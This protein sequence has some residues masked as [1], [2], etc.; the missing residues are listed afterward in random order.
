MAYQ[1]LIYGLCGGILLLLSLLLLSNLP[2]V[3][4]RANIFLGIC[5]FFLC[6]VF[7][8][9]LLENSNYLENAML[10]ASLEFGRWA[11]FPCFFIAIQLY[12]SPDQPYKKYAIHFVPTL[13]LV[14]LLWSPYTLPDVLRY[15]IRYFLY[16][17]LLVYG[18]WSYVLLYKHR[19]LLNT[20]STSPGAIDLRWIMNIWWVILFLGIMSLVTRFFPLVSLLIDSSYVVGILFFSYYALSQ[21]AIYPVRDEQVPVIKAA[22]LSKDKERLTMEQ[23]QFF[24]ERLQDL[25][26]KDQPYLDPLLSLPH[27]AERIGLSIHELSY[28]LNTGI[29]SNFYQFINGYRIRY[30]QQL[31]K[32]N[33]LNGYSIQEISIR[34]GFNSKTTFYTSFK[35]EVGMT[36]KRYLL[37]VE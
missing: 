32:D 11:I 2:K 19:L 24:K 34:S 3:N 8:Q 22:V 13:I 17:Q 27:L 33:I 21:T 29:D 23:V 30:A 1:A 14:P 28:V 12:L 37:K 15:V 4:K 20:F 9:L 6:S 7:V 25:M 10:L 35:Q 36:P 16:G 31:L 18:V 5:S 26:D